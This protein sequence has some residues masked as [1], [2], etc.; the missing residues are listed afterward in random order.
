MVPS[1]GRILDASR[2]T[3][4]SYSPNSDMQACSTRLMRWLCSWS[5]AAQEGLGC[6]PPP[7]LAWP[8]PLG[9]R[10]SAE[11]SSAPSFTSDGLRGGPASTACSAGTIC[12][13]CLCMSIRANS[14]SAGTR[15]QSMSSRKLASK[16]CHRRHLK[17][18]QV[19][20]SP[21]YQPLEVDTQC[22]GMIPASE[23]T[24][25]SLEC[26]ILPSPAPGVPR[27]CLCQPGPAV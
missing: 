7:P 2:A 19:A 11:S 27:I 22:V 12:C 21:P 20:G 17:H 14:C 1:G 15:W 10:V 13:K 16:P 24:P 18:Q 25:L 6:T 5:R 8:P 3:T 4:S 9:C 26:A 23:Q